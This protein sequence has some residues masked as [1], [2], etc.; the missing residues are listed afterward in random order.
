M[1]MVKDILK[2]KS[3]NVWSVGPGASVYNAMKIMADREVG[4]L[5]VIEGTKL[6]GI[7]SER[8]YA[9]KVILQGRSSKNT[10]VKEIMTTHVMYARHEQKV[11][12][13]MV[14][15]TQ[16]RFRHLP[17]IDEGQLVGV[18]SI[19]DLVKSIITEQ[20]FA[21]EQLERYISA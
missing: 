14:L 1:K 5:M 4:A 10:Q 3:R 2:V 17:V 6:I 8:D 19:G 9:R 20:R 7:I 16:K 12:G 13:C 11:E 21:T 18:I 15:M